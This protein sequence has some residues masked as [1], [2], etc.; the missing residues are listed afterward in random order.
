MTIKS[1]VIPHQIK[2][3]LQ[4]CFAMPKGSSSA[5][6]GYQLLKRGAVLIERVLIYSY[7]IFQFF[8]ISKFLLFIN[9]FYD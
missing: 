2:A 6:K 3:S 7:F 4:I 9:H 8:K 5:I 1:G